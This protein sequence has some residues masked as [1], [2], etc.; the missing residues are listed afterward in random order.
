VAEITHLVFGAGVG[1]KLRRVNPETAIIGLG[2]ETD[3]IEHEELGLGSEHGDVAD[4]GLLHIGLR[5]ASNR[6]G[7][8]LIRLVGKRLQ[9]VTKHGQRALSEEGIDHCGLAV[10]HE[11]HVRLVDR[12]P[13][14]DRG[15]VK[16]DAFGEGFLV[17]EARIHRYVLHLTARIGEAQIDKLDLFVFDLLSGTLCVCHI[18]P[19]AYV[20]APSV[21][22][23]ALDCSSDM[24]IT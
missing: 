16:H 1:G 7:I 21:H 19:L 15:A 8:A 13:A 10:G 2:A 11:L 14:G 20:I 5:L 24:E 18:S 9:H 3:V 22:G 6:A 17:H 23:A 12:L 4:A